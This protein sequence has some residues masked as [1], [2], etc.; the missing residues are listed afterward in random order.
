M[1]QLSLGQL[2]PCATTRE[3]PIPTTQEPSAAIKT[4]SSQ[5]NCSVAKVMSDSL[6]PH[7]L[8]HT[9]LPCKYRKRMEL[10]VQC[11]KERPSSSL[12][13]DNLHIRLTWSEAKVKA[14]VKVQKQAARPQALITCLWAP[15]LSAVAALSPPI[16]LAHTLS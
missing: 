5:I 8:Q 11:R 14:K 9:R 12:E 13:R 10:E 4:W 2:N 7:E 16:L 3:K 6:R 1:R 15:H